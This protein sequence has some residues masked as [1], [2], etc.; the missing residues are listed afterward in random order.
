[1]TSTHALAPYNATARP[2]DWKF[3]RTDLN[4]L[5]ARVKQHDRHAPSPLAA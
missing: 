5:L 1:V 2:F 3:T 4:K